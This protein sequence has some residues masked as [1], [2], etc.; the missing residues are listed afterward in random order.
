MN[1]YEKLSSLILSRKEWISY[2]ESSLNFSWHSLN[3]KFISVNSLLEKVE[4]ALFLSHTYLPPVQMMD[5][6]FPQ[7]DTAVLSSRS[8]NIIKDTN[9]SSFMDSHQVKTSCTISRTSILNITC[10]ESNNQE[11]CALIL[12]NK[13]A[14][15]SN[16]HF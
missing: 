15:P 11:K 3:F 6:R 1:L 10:R 9:S 5:F 12:Q 14:V 4:L 8:D 2:L 16:T 13:R 7:Q